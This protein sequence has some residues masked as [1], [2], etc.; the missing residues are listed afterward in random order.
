MLA[1]WSELGCCWFAGEG[2]GSFSLQ[3]VRSVLGEC[4]GHAGNKD[5][6]RLG[7]VGMQACV[8]PGTLKYEGQSWPLLR[9]MILVCCV[10]AGLA[11]SKSQSFRLP[12][13]LSF[14]FLGTNPE[15]FRTFQQE[16]SC[17]PG[18]AR[19]GLSRG[20]D[21]LENWSADLAF[22]CRYCTPPF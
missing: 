11:Y 12:R 18:K 1:S 21:L 15:T 3:V 16:V 13:P 14:F 10:K 7:H 5:F 20:L 8:C 17:Q 19:F 6:R 2:C 22:L 4:C 9:R